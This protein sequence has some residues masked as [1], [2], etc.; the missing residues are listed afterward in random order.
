LAKQEGKSYL[1]GRNNLMSA[2]EADAR[3]FAD[4]ARTTDEWQIRVLCLILLERVQRPDAVRQFEE[5]KPTGLWRRGWAEQ[6]S[7]YARAI[8]EKGARAPMLLVEQ[9]W[10]GNLANV[11]PPNWRQFSKVEFRAYMAVAL[12]LLKVKEARDVIEMLLVEP[13][14]RAWNVKDRHAYVGTLGQFRDPRSVPALIAA[15]DAIPTEDVLWSHTHLRNVTEAALQRCADGESLPL[16]EAAWG[17]ATSREK[18]LALLRTIRIVKGLSPNT[19]FKEL[20][21]YVDRKGVPIAKPEY[22]HAWS[23]AGGIGRVSLEDGRMKALTE[24]GESLPIDHAGLGAI[25]EGLTGAGDHGKCGFVDQDGKVVVPFRFEF[26]KPFS[27]GL[28][29]VKLGGKW[30]LIDKTGRMIIEPQFDRVS[31]FSDGMA[32]VVAGTKAG[33]VSAAGRLVVPPKYE[34]VTVFSAGLAGVSAGGKWGFIDKRGKMVV[35]PQYDSA[36]EF[37]E[38]RAAVQLG[39]K[40]GFIDGTGGFALGPRYAEVGDFSTGFARVKTG[41]K[42]GYVGLNGRVVIGPRF[43]QVTDFLP[44]F[45]ATAARVGTKWGFI[46]RSGKT[47]LEPQFSVVC[48]FS[49]GFCAVELDGKWGFVDQSGKLAIRPRFADVRRFSHGLA[50][51]C[52]LQ[53]VKRPWGIEHKRVWGYIDTTGRMIIEPQFHRAEPFPERGPAAV[54]VRRKIN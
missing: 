4:L 3:P 40:W 24:T 37:S 49:D 29:R 2:A 47:V 34:D 45:T 36:R 48:E 32:V 30:G 42:W 39:G 44:S 27:L 41:D 17:G 15:L 33:F 54:A 6:L 38:G 25:S 23:F 26:V 1:K 53:E 28:A 19:A 10:K 46:D 16:L 8:A 20:W 35:E 14:E 43:D 11:R 52:V 50:P 31:V 51:A 13:Y 18:G 5:W 9:L 12:R 7:S 21:G 22:V